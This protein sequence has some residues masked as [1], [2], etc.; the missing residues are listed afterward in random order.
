M[1][2]IKIFLFMICVSMITTQINAQGPQIQTGNW[3][4]GNPSFLRTT[5]VENVNLDTVSGVISLIPTT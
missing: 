4:D 2:K 3:K 1:K 5:P